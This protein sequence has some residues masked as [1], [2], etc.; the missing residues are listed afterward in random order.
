MKKILAIIF[1]V[2]GAT[3]WLFGQ[4][5][6]PVIGIGVGVHALDSAIIQES[7]TKCTPCPTE[8]YVAWEFT[9]DANCHFFLNSD[10]PELVTVQITQGCSQ[11]LFD[12]CVSLPPRGVAG[13]AYVKEFAVIGDCQIYVSG[14]V[15][16]SI[17]IDVKGL[18]T[19]QEE[20]FEV[21]Y[22]M[23]TC[24][25]LLNTEPAR[26][27]TQVIYKRLDNGLIY[28]TPLRAGIYVAETF[29]PAGRKKL[30]LVE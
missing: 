24:G 2:L 9:P 29:F 25:V 3:Y 21:L 5:G 1:I 28:T 18:P 27:T 19:P 7:T 17:F 10:S 15:G 16:Q 26:E 4:C 20:L 14:I 23:D 13:W 6:F 12:T 8:G 11:V 22:D 30:I